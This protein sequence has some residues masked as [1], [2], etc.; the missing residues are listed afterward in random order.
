MCN[1]YGFELDMDSSMTVTSIVLYA[2]EGGGGFSQYAGSLPGGLAF[3]DTYPVVVGKL[4]QPLELVG[5]SG[6]TE[7]SA[8]YSAPP[9][10]LSVTFT[11]WY[12]SAEYL[13]RATVHMIAIGLT[14]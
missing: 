7:V 11:T 6:A 5:G 1:D 4:G 13:A 3:T 12:K 2:N 14:Q 10:E 9:Y 8:R